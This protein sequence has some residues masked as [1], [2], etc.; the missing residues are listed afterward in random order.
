MLTAG[1][2]LNEGDEEWHMTYGGPALDRAY[3]VQQTSDGGFIIAGGTQSH[4]A[5]WYDFWLVKTDENGKV[6]WS[7][8]YGGP[9]VD[10]AY[11]VQQTSDSGYLAAGKTD[12]YG[13]G[14]WDYW[15]VKVD[16]QGNEEWSQTYGGP[17]ED[18]AFSA[19]QTSDGGYIIAGYTGS[20]GAGGVDFWLVKAA[21]NGT[22]EWRKTYGG[23][24]HD[25]AYSVQQ[26]SDGGYVIV[27]WT[28]SYGPGG[29]N[30]WL[31]K[32]AGNGTEEWSN[33]YGGNKDDKARA[34]QQTSDGGYIIAGVTES[35][36]AGGWDLWL[37]KVDRQGNEEWG[38]AFGGPD[39]DGANA[40]QQTSD[41]GYIV[42]G[43]TNSFG[44]GGA[45]FW[46]IK[47]NGVGEEEWSRTFDANGYEMASSVQQTFDGGYI[48]AGETASCDDE[49]EC[50][51]DF[52]VIKVK[53]APQ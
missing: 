11:S 13:D 43:E 22:M 16:E 28:S 35:Y 52:L 14:G 36:G 30:A 9:G 8:P 15:L 44:A 34:V 21:G 46:V 50:D 6:E 33:A 1:C 45:D 12:S 4:G 51:W 41:G 19:Q 17:E 48:V 47:T 29:I 10:I 31:I 27:G 2:K 7:K 18:W 5:G 23:V 37:V 53:G 42:A 20:Y 40:V 24:A 39:P 3:S 32:V 26:T 38:K 25:T 49:G